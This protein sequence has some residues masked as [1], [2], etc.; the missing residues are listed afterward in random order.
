MVDRIPLTSHGKVDRAALL[1]TPAAE[2]TASATDAAPRTPGEQVL[3][4]LFATVLGLETAGPGTNFFEAGG[5]SLLVMR[6]AAAAEQALGREVPI[7]A[8][9][10]APTPAALARQLGGPVQP[11]TDGLSPVLTLRAA[12][13]RTPLFCLPPGMGLGW[14]YSALLPHLTGRPVHALQPDALRRVGDLP[15]SIG[16]VAADYVRLIRSVQPEGPYLL[17]G[18]SFGGLLSYEVAA[19]LRAD[20]QPVGLVALVDA[21]PGDGSPV[22]PATAETLALSVLLSQAIPGAAGRPERAT[23][24]EAI[25]LVR[26]ADGPLRGASAARLGYLLDLTVRYIILA[27]D[28]KPPRYEGKV[29]LFSAAEPDAADAGAKAGV[30]RRTANDVRVHELDGTHRQS[31]DPPAA[32]AIARA[33]APILREF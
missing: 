5:H 19:R 15:D 11:G 16:Q 8:V 31:M 27:Q 26:S 30:W 22:D 18:R 28:Y 9:Y 6:L 33:R 32:A 29:V 2:I 21:L 10:D 25:H 3:S 12:G 13:H 7:S 1:A 14:S 24:A 4:E 20:G 17:L 23:R